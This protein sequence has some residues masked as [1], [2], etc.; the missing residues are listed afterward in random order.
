ML[1]VSELAIKYGISIHTIRTW[2]RE[3]K[4]KAKFTPRGYAINEEYFVEFI[5]GRKFRKGV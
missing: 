4:L 1:S 5:K 2:I 3:K